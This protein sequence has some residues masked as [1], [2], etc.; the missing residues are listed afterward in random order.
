MNIQYTDLNGEY[1]LFTPFWDAA[2]A[3]FHIL[4]AL[5]EVHLLKATVYTTNV[6]HNYEVI[7]LK[8]S[9]TCIDKHENILVEDCVPIVRELFGTRGMLVPSTE[10]FRNYILEYKVDL[11]P[12]VKY[13]PDLAKYVKPWYC[14][15]DKHK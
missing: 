8:S 9:Y 5:D 2:N 3:S 1:F 13:Y 14:E 4:H 12:L 7:M 10:G 6:N 15:Y 11:T